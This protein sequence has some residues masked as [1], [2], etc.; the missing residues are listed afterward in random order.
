MIDDD[1]PLLYLWAKNLLTSRQDYTEYIVC[2]IKD[3]NDSITP[4]N[5]I[6]FNGKLYH[7]VSYEK[8]FRSSWIALH[9]KEWKTTDVT[10][11]WEMYALTSINGEST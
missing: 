10:I 8:S 3:S 2:M 5:Y 9:L 1:A 4:L 7:I 6:Q 11:T